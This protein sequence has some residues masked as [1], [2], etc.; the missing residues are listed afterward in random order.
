MTPLG[1]AAFV[2]AGAAGAS[3]RYLVELILTERVRAV[4]PWGTWVVNV[5]GSFLFGLLTGLGINHGLPRTPRVVLGVGFC[6]AFTTF[7]ALAAETVR[8]WES[9]AK[10]AAAV[11]AAGTVVAALLAAAAGL[12]LT[13]AFNL[14]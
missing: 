4:L 8:L 5:S 1:W 3:A 10:G 14:K 6:G 9:G 2:V 13:A 11:N 12:A 7:S